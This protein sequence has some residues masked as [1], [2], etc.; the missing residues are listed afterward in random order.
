MGLAPYEH[1]PS[2]YT[3]WLPCGTLIKMHYA[4]ET[5]AHRLGYCYVCVRVSKVVVNHDDLLIHW[6]YRGSPISM[7]FFSTIPSIV[8]L[9]IILSGINILVLNQFPLARF[10]GSTKFMLCGDPLYVNEWIQSK[11]FFWFLIRSTT[12]KH[13]WVD[14]NLTRV[15]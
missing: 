6:R 4:T 1:S 13:L 8:W 9:K 10:P 5:R 7:N 12:S 11:Y 14:K 3:D 2:S 15:K